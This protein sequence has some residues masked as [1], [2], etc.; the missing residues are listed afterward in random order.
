MVRWQL[1]D[2]TRLADRLNLA[3]VIDACASIPSTTAS[4]RRRIMIEAGPR[5]ISAFLSH[6]PRLVDLLIVTTGT[7][8]VGEQ[9]RPAVPPTRTVVLEHVKSQL[10]GPDFVVANRVC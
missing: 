8:I 4:P 7:T 1:A 9:G 3:L 2:L 5:L 6:E 10:F